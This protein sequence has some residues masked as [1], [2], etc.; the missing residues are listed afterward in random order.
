MTVRQWQ[1]T[2]GWV[3]YSGTRMEITDLLTTHADKRSDIREHFAAAGLKRVSRQIQS[4]ATGGAVMF[5]RYVVEED[6]T[7]RPTD[8]SDVG[9][10]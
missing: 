7:P 9:H 6:G 2:D 10:A 4:G 8:K 5:A 3:N 1:S